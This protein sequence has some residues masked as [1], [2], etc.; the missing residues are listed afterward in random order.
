MKTVYTKE[1]LEET[2]KK[3]KRHWLKVHLRLKFARS[4]KQK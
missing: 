2:L 4:M 3:G 1:Q